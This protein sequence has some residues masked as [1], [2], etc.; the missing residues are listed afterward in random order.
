MYHTKGLETIS[1]IWPAHNLYRTLMLAPFL[2]WKPTFRSPLSTRGAVMFS[3]SLH[4][5]PSTTSRIHQ[6]PPLNARNA[7]KKQKGSILFIFPRQPSCQDFP[8]CPAN[9]SFDKESAIRCA[10]LR[11]AR[12]CERNRVWILSLV[13]CPVCQLPS[14]HSAALDALVFS[15]PFSFLGGWW[16]SQ[17]GRRLNL[18]FFKL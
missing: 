18:H 10:S 8:S 9:F 13:I 4:L 6:H 14:R 11:E 7:T 2:C 5:Q 12:D 17:G 15:D 1:V 16:C 3:H